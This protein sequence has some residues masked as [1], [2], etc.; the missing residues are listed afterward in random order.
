MPQYDQQSL[1]RRRND[2]HLERVE[3]KLDQALER[4]TETISEVVRVES[5]LRSEIRRVDSLNG[6]VEKIELAIDSLNEAKMSM[7]ML[8]K[9]ISNNQKKISNIELEQARQ[10]EQ[11]RLS[12]WIFK[13][14]IAVA[15]V[16]VTVWA[17]LVQSEK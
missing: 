8:T 13:A 17:V 7:F 14:A 3:D 11:H 15:G 4:L 16:A 5:E 1:D 6:S 12:E 9:T 10:R 2:A